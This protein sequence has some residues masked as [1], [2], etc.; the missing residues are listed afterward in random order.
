[1]SSTLLCT[2]GTS[3]IESNLKNLSSS[4]PNRPENWSKLKE[5]F[6]T[7]NYSQL[8]KELIKI[9]P[10]HRICGAEINTI[11][12]NISKNRIMPERIVFLVSDTD[13]GKE[14]GILLTHYFKESDY[15][16][17]PDVNYQ[18][19]EK[20]Q[21]SNP[22]EF[23]TKGLRNLVS[24]MGD[25]IQKYGSE[26]IVIDATGGYKAQIAVAVIVGQALNIQVFYKHERFS[27][28]IDFPPLPISLD[29]DLLGKNADLFHKLEKDQLISGTELNSFE[30]IEKLKVFLTEVEIDNTALYE[31]NAIGQLYLT[32]F[33][34]RFPK[35]PKLI[36]LNEKDRKEPT[37]SNDHHF[38]SGFKEFVNKVWEE[39]K[40]IKTCYSTPY[41]KQKGIK[42]TG[43]TVKQDE[44]GYFLEGTF[45]ADFRAKY[46]LILSD[47]SLESLIWAADSL[48]QKYS[49]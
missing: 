14:T 2:V 25:L 17:I 20:L 26:K 32:S 37:F 9:E 46:R 16:I 12:E 15:F 44:K 40:W 13:S 22:K 39:N 6:D 1:M 41:H 36:K 4:M 47:E 38:P 48:N 45:K 23:K 21:D 8:V 27:E 35:A 49:N 24:S 10:S 3:L 34:L 29:Y 7:K 19:I 5:Y 43:F 33:R 31:L 42:E 30:D 11:Y 18:V 28:V